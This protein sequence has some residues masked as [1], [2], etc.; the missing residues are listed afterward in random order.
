MRFLIV[1][2]SD[3]PLKYLSEFLTDMGHQVVA[4]ARNGQ[5]AVEL[6]HSQR[7]DAVVMDI[8][9]PRLNGLD[10]LKRMQEADPS[11]PVVITSCLRSCETAL[12]AEHLGAAY[13]LSKPFDPIRLGKVVKKIAG[14]RN[15]RGE[16]GPH[17][18]KAAI[19]PSPAIEP[20]DQP[21]RRLQGGRGKTQRPRGAA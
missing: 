19:T 5:E 2:D 7:P 10:A 15:G 18:A 3:D 6:F 21:K 20:G 4:S 1:D 16:K 11:V 9:M 12:E 14:Q 17:P 8:I 13:C